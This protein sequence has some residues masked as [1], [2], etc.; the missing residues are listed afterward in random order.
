[1]PGSTHGARLSSHPTNTNMA[2]SAYDVARQIQQMRQY[3]DIP[4]FSFVELPKDVLSALLWLKA[5]WRNVE[6]MEH[7]IK[8]GANPREKNQG[9]TVLDSFMQGHDGYWRD[10]ERVKEVEEGV[11]MLA[12]YGVTHLDAVELTVKNCLELI[13]ASEYLCTFF[14]VLP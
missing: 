6:E 11:K 1:M 12:Q 10:K 5:E 9:F 8:M 14:K 7:L 4:V 2:Y 3:H 13:R